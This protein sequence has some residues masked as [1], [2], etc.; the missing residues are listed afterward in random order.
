[1]NRICTKANFGGYA[2]SEGDTLFP[3]HPSLY[4]LNDGYREASNLQTKGTAIEN[5]KLQI[6]T[7]SNSIGD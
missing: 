7:A 4:Y 6:A 3:E 5:W 1:M 2:D